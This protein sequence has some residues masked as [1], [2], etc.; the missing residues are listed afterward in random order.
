MTMQ[1]TPW[2]KGYIDGLTG[3]PASNFEDVIDAREYKDGYV[4][5]L[6]DRKNII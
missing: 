3:K 6:K 4:E 2:Y 1:D 5:G